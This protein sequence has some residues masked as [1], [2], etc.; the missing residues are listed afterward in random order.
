MNIRATLTVGTLLVMS[1]MTMAAESVQ[2]Y[3][4]TSS[5]GLITG[6]SQQKGKEK[7]IEVSSWSCSREATSGL[8]TGRRMPKW[9]ELVDVMAPRDAASGLPTGKRMHKPF[10]FTMEL[11]RAGMQILQALSGNERTMECMI[12]VTGDDGKTMTATLTE[13]SIDQILFQHHGNGAPP[14][15]QVSMNY[16]KITWTWKD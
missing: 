6:S 13:A 9:T 5:Q 8:P 3:L 7:W 2:V 1:A 14:T 15:E 16:T 12:A 10:V 11:D 4:R